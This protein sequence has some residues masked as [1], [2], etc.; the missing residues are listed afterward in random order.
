[1]RIGGQNSRFNQD[2]WAIDVIILPVPPW[3]VGRS[4]AGTENT[5][6]N[7]TPNTATSYQ[8]GDSSCSFQK[9]SAANHFFAHCMTSVFVFMFIACI[10]LI[11]LTILSRKNIF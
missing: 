6:V 11:M 10:F 1:M 2:Q 8:N 7:S 5:L 4:L 9:I 3:F